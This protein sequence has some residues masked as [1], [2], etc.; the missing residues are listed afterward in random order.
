L[1]PDYERAQRSE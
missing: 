1:K